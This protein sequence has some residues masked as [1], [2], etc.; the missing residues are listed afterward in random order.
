MLEGGVGD[1][2]SLEPGQ[3]VELT[4]GLVQGHSC[5][6]LL[7]LLSLLQHGSPGE[8]GQ[9]VKPNEHRGQHDFGQHFV[10]EARHMQD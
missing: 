5:V 7:W 8:L 9:D 10:S 6:D 4:R 3:D 1:R 2:A